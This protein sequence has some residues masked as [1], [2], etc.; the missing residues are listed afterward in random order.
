MSD[1]PYEKAIEETAKATGKALE[2]AKSAAPA[3][4]D[5]YGLVAGDWIE[6]KRKEH[7]DA[8]ARKTKKILK[9]RNV[10]PQSIPEQISIPLL[11]AAQGESRDEIQDLWAQLF[12]NA[13][14]PLRAENVRP[15]F[16]ETVKQL[17]PIDVRILIRIKS[18]GTSK[19][20]LISEIAKDE[21]LRSSA[22]GI[23]VANLEKLGCVLR[24]GG[25]QYLGLSEYG[26]ELLFAVEK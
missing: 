23:S 17:Q 1:N 13:M 26:H 11:S 19:Q 10:E 8:L 15:E 18:V 6:A 21:H 24:T 12:A 9:D 3:I 5:I 20:L 22:A 4:G 7:R 25:G 14:D 2:L 16:I